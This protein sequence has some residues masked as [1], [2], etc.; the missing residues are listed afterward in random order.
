MRRYGNAGRI[1]ALALLWG[2]SFVWIKLSLRG[3]TPTQILVTRLALGA[4]TLLV[5]LRARGERLPSDRATWLHL[6]CA[7][8]FGNV[9]PYLLF[10]VAEQQVDSGVAGMLNATTPLW[11]VVLAVA[12]RQHRHPSI[13]QFVGVVV[14]LVGTALIFAPW[15]AGTQFT[16]RGALLCLLAATSYAISYVYIA[17]FLATT[18]NNPLALSAGQLL[19]ATGPA[20]LALPTFDG[21]R[22]PHWRVD[23]IASVVILGVLGTGLAYVLNYRIISDDGAIAASVVIYLLPVVAIILG[24]VMLGESLTGHALLGVLVVLVG[25]ATTRR[26]L[27]SQHAEPGRLDDT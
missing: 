6:V 16:S 15:T 25:V 5:I 22:A 3:L 17:R 10:A 11:T 4:S 18:G 24:A 9:V 2:S 23:A 20:L 13:M 19:A 7:A 8:L 1:A 26:Q 21:L 14:G 27:P 12:T